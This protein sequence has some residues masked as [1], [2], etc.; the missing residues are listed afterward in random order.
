M[1]SGTLPGEVRARSRLRRNA[2]R[3]GVLRMLS[4]LDAAGAAVTHKEIPNAPAC[5][6]GL[7]VYEG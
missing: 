2:N 3:V 1:P 4:A 5:G 6:V 7:V